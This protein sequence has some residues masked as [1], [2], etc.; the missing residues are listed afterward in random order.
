MSKR[1][2]PKDWAEVEALW[3]LGQITRTE[4]AKK[5]GISTTAVSVHMKKK[6]IIRGSKVEEQ[7]RRVSAKIMEETSSNSTIHSQR[8]QEAKD[9]HYQM[10]Q[11]LSQLVW[12]KVVDTQKAGQPVSTIHH[13]LKALETAINVLAAAR[14]E[15]WAVLGLDKPDVVDVAELPEL[16]VSELTAEQI[17][18]MINQS[19]DFDYQMD[20]NDTNN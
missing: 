7:R 6:G 16:V 13:E 10:N 19:D 12:K 2:T 5:L 17:E 4:I 3:E 1:I 14:K 18:E 8:V 11:A 9:Q 15:K 20:G